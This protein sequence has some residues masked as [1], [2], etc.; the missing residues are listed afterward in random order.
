[1]SRAP[2][3]HEGEIIGEV[4]NEVVTYSPHD[5]ILV[6]R[7]N[8]RAGLVEELMKEDMISFDITPNPAVRY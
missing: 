2:L 4:L 5:H 1:M 6:I 3:F 8:K 7:L